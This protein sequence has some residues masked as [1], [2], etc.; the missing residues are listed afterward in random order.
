MALHIIILAAGRGQR[1]YSNKPKVLRQLAGKPL[2]E[3]VINA[4]QMLYPEVIH[5]VHGADSQ[6]IMECFK[7][8][9]VN[10]ILQ[11]EPLGTGHAVMQVLPQL[12]PGSDVLILCG[13]VPLITSQTLE[14]L[15]AS[16]HLKSALALLCANIPHPDGFGRI[17]RDNHGLI[18]AIVEYKDASTLELQISEVYSGICCLSTATL[19]QLFAN[20]NRNNSQQEYYLTDI[21]R[22]A[23]NENLA[24]ES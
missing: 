18:R 11:E 17:L 6:Q 5:V 24:V 13:D 12:P 7:H 4:A 15:V 16:A 14:R 8:Y 10:W 22:I 3:W 1:M 9:P 23:V 2:L 20:L 19:T 21:V